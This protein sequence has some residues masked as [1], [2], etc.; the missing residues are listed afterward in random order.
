MSPVLQRPNFSSAFVWTL[1][2][3]AECLTCIA[4][5]LHFECPKIECPNIGR[6]QV[7]IVTLA[8]KNK[9]RK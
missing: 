4:F 7:K 3:E 2:Y 6:K 1:L 8:L 5:S 9:D